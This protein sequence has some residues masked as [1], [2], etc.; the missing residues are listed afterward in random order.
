M[1][2]WEKFTAEQPCYWHSDQK[3]KNGNYCNGCD[4]QPPDDEKPNGRKPPIRIAWEKDYDGGVYPACPACGEMPYSTE[5]CI[6][7]GQKF[8]Q[9]DKKLQDYATPPEEVRMDCVVCG[10]KNTMVGTRA[11]SNGHFHG[12]CEACGALMME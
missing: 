9:D 7:C 2:S 3:C 5:R 10:G 4:L 6:F 8:I 1:I 12:R 11:K